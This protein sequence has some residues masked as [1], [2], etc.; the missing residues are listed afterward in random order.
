M[1]GLLARSDWELI[2]S[3]DGIKMF[4]RTNEK[5]LSEVKKCVNFKKS[6]KDVF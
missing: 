1:Q 6:A 3:E 5:G 4:K 2:H